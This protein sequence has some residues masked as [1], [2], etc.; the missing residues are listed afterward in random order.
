VSIQANFQHRSQTMSRM[1]IRVC[2]IAV[3]LPV[4]VL[5][6]A[7]AA[8]KIPGIGP[9]GEVKQLHT[10]FEFTEGPAFDN[11]GNMYFSDVQGNKIYRVD[12]SNQLSVF[13]DPSNHANGLMFN[14]KGQLYACEMDGRLVSIDLATKAVKPLAAEY[15]GKRFNAPNDLVIDRQGGVYFTDPHFRAPMPLPQGTVAVYYLEPQG[16]VTRLIEDVKAPN[17]VILSPDEKTLYVIPSQQKEMLAYPIELPGKLGARRT[18]CTL[19]QPPG[20]D[21]AGGDGLTMDTKGNL[22]ITSALGVQVFDPQGKQLGLVPFPEQ[23]ANCTFGGPGNRTLYVT[24]RK[25]LY[26]VEMEAA[27][28]V[29]AKAGN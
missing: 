27:G 3:C 4:A 20:R 12:S 28:H 10:N 8:E 26:A 22:Y 18:F 19:Q 24:A 11:Q 17:G 13:L 29:F 9:V 21:N 16:R 6:V 5:L 25:S 2:C 7:R 15:E 1:M 14:G 23:P